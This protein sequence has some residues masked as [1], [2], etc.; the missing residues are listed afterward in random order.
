MTNGHH[1]A[2]YEIRLDLDDPTSIHGGQLGAFQPE[3]VRPRC[4][5]RQE[6]SC[7]NP[8]PD[9]SGRCTEC[10]ALGSCESPEQQHGRVLIIRGYAVFMTS[11]SGQFN[12]QTVP[13]ES[14]DTGHANGHH[15]HTSASRNQYYASE[16]IYLIRPPP[17][18][19]RQTVPFIRTSAATPPP[20][21]PLLS[22]QTHGSYCLKAKHIAQ[23]LGT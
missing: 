1:Q 18:L 17:P 2:A 21:H 7:L 10:Q 12:T 16:F 20:N 8:Q 11:G 9:S 19:H 23:R 13:R 3:I 14:Y 22:F 5:E 15:L 6:Q 4:D